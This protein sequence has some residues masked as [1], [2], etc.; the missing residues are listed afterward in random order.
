MR[1][2]TEHTLLSVITATCHPLHEQLRF[3][4][5]FI[6]GENLKAIKVMQSVGSADA[7]VH[8]ANENEEVNWEINYLVFDV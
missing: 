2:Y 8:D 1:H 4:F 7:V 5:S 3:A 6:S